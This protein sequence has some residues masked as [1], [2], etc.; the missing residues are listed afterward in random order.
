MNLLLNMKDI[1]KILAKIHF[2]CKYKKNVKKKHIFAKTCL[3]RC[4]KS[5][6]H[7]F[8]SLSWSLRE[9]SSLPVFCKCGEPW[10]VLWWSSFKIVYNNPNLSFKMATVT[11]NRNFF[12]CPLLLYY[13]FTNEVA[14]GY[15]NTTVRPSVTS[16]WTL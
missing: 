12:N 11:K 8:T 1:N 14:K 6:C 3:W 7:A 9:K 15:S 16:L 5:P 10:M 4:W 2:K 13:P